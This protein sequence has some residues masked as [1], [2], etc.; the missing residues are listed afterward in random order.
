MHGKLKR[1]CEGN[2]FDYVDNDYINGKY[3]NKSLLLLNKAGSKLF[4][5]NLLD[6]IKEFMIF[7]H[8]HT[9][10]EFAKL[11]AFGA[12]VLY[13]PSYLACIRALRAFS[14]YVP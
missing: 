7:K 11:F 2:D 5:K 1:Y 4:S 13:V 6:C 9:H 12:F 8:A 3:L 10:A 14:P